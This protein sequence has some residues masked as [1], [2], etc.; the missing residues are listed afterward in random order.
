MLMPITYNNIYDKICSFE[1][2]CLAYKKARKGKGSR[3]YVKEFEKDLEKN[4]LKLESELRHAKYRPKPLKTFVIH[5]P[6]TRVISASDFRDRIVHHAICNIIGPI[7]DRIFIYDSYANRKKKGAHAALK[8]FDHFKRS[9][10]EN[11]KLIDEKDKNMVIG[12]ALKAD[13]RHYFDTV[14]HEILLKIIG[15]RIKDEKVLNLIKIILDNYEPKIPGKG[16]PLGNLT[17]QFFANIY[18][19]ELDYFVKHELRSKFYVRYV[20]DFVILHNRKYILEKWKNEIGEFLNMLKLELHP[21]KTKIYPLH[22]GTN[23]LGFRVFY[24]YKLP[25]KRNVRKFKK[26]MSRLLISYRSEEAAKN[27]VIKLM[28]GWF[29]YAIWGNTYKMRKKIVEDLKA[30]NQ[31]K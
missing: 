6:K 25:Y 21:E 4:L 5:D 31:V 23:L 16:M 8:R 3:Q 30:Q 22:S 2:L 1:N 17:S 12:Y 13:V 28:S 20:D 7:F 27:D 19:N 14:D 9:V 26:K 15:K 18:L 10:S 24:N 29:A 11:G